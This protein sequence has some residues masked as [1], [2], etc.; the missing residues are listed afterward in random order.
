MTERVLTHNPF[1]S[2]LLSLGAVTTA[3]GSPLARR[4]AAFYYHHL[5]GVC[6]IQS[7]VSRVI[8]QSNHARQSQIEKCACDDI[9]LTE[10]YS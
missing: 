2:N 4:R 5:G 1:C 3:G 9:M 7:A 10:A 8:I 6:A